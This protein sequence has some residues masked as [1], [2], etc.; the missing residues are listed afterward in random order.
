[1]YAHRLAPFSYSTVS[2]QNPHYLAHWQ[3]ALLL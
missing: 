3:A 1:M 2:C